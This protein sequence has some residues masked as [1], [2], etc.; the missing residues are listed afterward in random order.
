MNA[1]KKT[2]LFLLLLSGIAA[3]PLTANA[4]KVTSLPVDSAAVPMTLSTNTA[5]EIKNERLKQDLKIITVDGNAYSGTES[6]RDSVREIVNLFLY[7][8]YHHFQD[9]LAPYFMLMSKDAKLALGIGGAIRLRGWYDFGG[10]IPNRGFAPYLIPVPDDPANRRSLDGTPAGTALFLRVIG[11]N[12]VLGDIVGYVQT[13][14]SAADN[15][16]K[17]KK[18]YLTI[19]DWTVGYTQTAF[20]DPAAE[21][22]TID[23]A[24]QSGKAGRSALQVRWDHDFQKPWSIGAGAAMPNGHVAADNVT[25]QSI[26]DWFPDVAAYI[27][28]RLP[29]NA[30][31]RLAGMLRVLP[32]RDLISKQNHNKIGWGAQLS[33]VLYPIPRLAIY[34]E[35][36]T[37]QGYSSYM[38]DLTIG[39][40]DLINNPE[41]PGV[42]YTPWSLG[43]NIGCKYNFTPNVYACM[44]L[45][46]ARNFDK[47]GANPDEYKYGLY[48]SWSVFWEPTPR[49]QFGAEY[50]HGRRNNVNHAHGS[51]N[52]VDLLFQFSF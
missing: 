26:S 38:G 5:D 39:Q 45:A 37:G 16:L 34:A 31:V 18:A 6:H 27:S 14:F 36:N 17:L 24:G 19:S 32:Y 43:L 49:L 2:L 10:S 52:R 50:L 12:P 1:M 20:N 25:T 42:M 47:F 41:K 48:G 7:D 46:E 15:T 30:H 13:E 3:A 8:Q 23:G 29:H 44:A 9:P 40:Y 35:A 51:A 21:A 28:Y 4:L 33:A 11:R 22:P